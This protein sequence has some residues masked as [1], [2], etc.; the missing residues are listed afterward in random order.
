MIILYAWRQLWSY[1]FPE[2]IVVCSCLSPQ[3]YYRAAQFPSNPAI[4]AVFIFVVD[5][6]PMVCPV[7]KLS[8]VNPVPYS[9]WVLSIQSE[10]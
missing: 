1:I 9:A 10:L 3:Q 8:W 2:C 5:L 7:F 4:I 6:W